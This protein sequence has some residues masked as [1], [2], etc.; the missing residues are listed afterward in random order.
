MSRATIASAVDQVLG[1]LVPPD[2]LEE[3]E[4]ILVALSAVSMPDL[5]S[6]VTQGLAR[7]GVTGA[8]IGVATVGRHTVVTLRAPARAQAAVSRLAA[9]LGVSVAPLAGVPA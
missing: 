4:T 1:G 9:T 3:G 7:E 6:R 5:A 2:E 8:G